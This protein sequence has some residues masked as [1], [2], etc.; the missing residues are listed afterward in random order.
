MAIAAPLDFASRVR[1]PT[2]S[3]SVELGA[4]S[5]VPMFAGLPTEVVAALAGS[6]SIRRLSRRT[7]L[8]AE[9]TLPSHV[10]VVLHGRLSAVRRSTSGREVSLETFQSGD[11][12]ADALALPDRPLSGDW[13]ATEAT[14]VLAIPRDAFLAQVQAVPG[15]A[16][17]MVAHTL[18]RLERSK[19]MAAGV[20][21]ADVPDRVMTALKALAASEGQPT[22]DGVL[23]PN[24]PTQQ[25]LANSIGACR[26][27][28][29]RVVSDL[30]RRGLITAKGRALLISRRAL[31]GG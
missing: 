2:A 1:R 14:D 7:V 23:V 5:G 30:A 21:L 24:R 13:E 27:T 29:S 22:D 15:L 10:F 26:E 17:S 6:A 25:E 12:L 3:P 16:I 28:V 9:G 19:S 31:A 8:V 11:V 18:A 20:V 4:L